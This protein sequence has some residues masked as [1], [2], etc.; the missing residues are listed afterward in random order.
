MRRP[1]GFTLLELAIVVAVLVVLAG[2]LLP[3]LSGTHDNAALIVTRS[4]LMNIRD[5]IAGRDPS[6]PAYVNDTG[7]MPQTLQDLYV[8]PGT[9]SGELAQFNPATRRGWHGPYLQDA[10][11]KYL[12]DV[13]RGFISAYGLDGDNAPVDAWNHPIVL[14]VPNVAGADQRKMFS[15]LISAGPDGIIQSPPDLYPETGSREDDL[16]LFIFRADAPPQ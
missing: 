9:L 11:G 13:A 4:T 10:T 6:R 8:L 14:Q 1:N 12:V 16:V 5:A 15:R 3:K 2:I 7:Q